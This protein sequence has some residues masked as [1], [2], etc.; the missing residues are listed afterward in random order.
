MSDSKKKLK[1]PDGDSVMQVTPGLSI[2]PNSRANIAKYILGVRPADVNK[3]NI[4]CC[5]E[6]YSDFE[7]YCVFF[8]KEHLPK[9]SLLY[10]DYGADYEPARGFYDVEHL[11]RIAKQVKQ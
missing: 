11:E 6:R 4:E 1:G 5:F 3:V 8:A 9:D 7:V 2:F 10:Y